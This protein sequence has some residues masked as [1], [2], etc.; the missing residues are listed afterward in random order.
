VPGDRWIKSAGTGPVLASGCRV[1]GSAPLGG[2]L[3]SA[4]HGYIHRFQ[5]KTEDTA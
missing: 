5:V 1:L 2:V 4:P 3:S